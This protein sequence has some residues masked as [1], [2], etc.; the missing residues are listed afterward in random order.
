MVSKAVWEVFPVPVTDGAHSGGQ[1]R[2]HIELGPHHPV[3]A[4]WLFSSPR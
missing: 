2:T 1:R 4:G 3:R